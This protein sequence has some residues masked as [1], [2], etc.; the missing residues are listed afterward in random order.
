MESSLREYRS[1]IIGKILSM[2]A[3]LCPDIFSDFVVRG[4]NP[5]LSWREE[6]LKDEGLGLDKLISLKILL[7]NRVENSRLT[8]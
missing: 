6:M 2:P 5:T 1:K 4:D 3:S 7:E 8:F